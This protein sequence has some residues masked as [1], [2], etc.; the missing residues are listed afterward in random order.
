MSRPRN[1]YAAIPHAIRDQAPDLFSD[2]ALLGTWVQLLVV[3]D[4][5]WPERGEVPRLVDDGLYRRLVD[6]GAV[7][8][9]APDEYLYRMPYLDSEEQ[10]KSDQGRADRLAGWHEQGKHERKPVKGCPICFPDGSPLGAPSQ[11]PSTTNDLTT[12]QGA[13]AAGGASAA[14]RAARAAPGWDRT[15]DCKPEYYGQH[16]NQGHHRLTAAGYVCD[17]CHPE[18]EG[19]HIP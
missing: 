3:A 2:A 12:L 1:R 14:A 18:T 17:A 7:I 4:M 9:A 13:P 5:A 16:L 6:M 19:D 15:K 8:P 10:R 11:E